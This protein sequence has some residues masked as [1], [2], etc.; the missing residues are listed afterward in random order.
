M[1]ETRERGGI[2]SV[3]MHR[4]TFS[5]WALLIDALDHCLNHI[6][7]ALQ[8][9]PDLGAAAM[10]VYTDKDGSKY[11]LGNAEVHSCLDWEAVVGWAQE[12]EG[13]GEVFA[14]VLD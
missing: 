13:R 9:R 6:R 14:E 2:I 5:L 8:C 10:K 1:S 7:Q 11:F 4:P 12:R 3:R